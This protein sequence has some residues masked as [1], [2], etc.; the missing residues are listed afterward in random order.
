MQPDSLAGGLVVE[1]S[2]PGLLILI[3]QVEA[4]RSP[5]GPIWIPAKTVRVRA[6]R[7]DPRRFDSGS[8]EAL[9]A[10][11]PGVV[12][13]VFLDLR[14]SVMLRSVP[15]P[16]R[17]YRIVGTATDSL[18]GETPLSLRSALL[19]GNRFRLEA[20]DHADSVLAGESLLSLDASTGRVAISLRR[21]AETLPP[22]PRKTPLLRK[23]W[24]QWTLVG[25]GAAL[26][27]TAAV[28]RRDG[29]RWYNRYLESSDRR[30]LDTYFDR[31]VRYDHLSLVS[32]GAGQALFTGGLVLLVNGSGR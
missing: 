31:A 26:T 9:A 27:G 5:V 18:L 7:D 8:D 22:S 15:E 1:T 21:V 2:P 4:G 29:D 30:V 13:R 10:L 24:L 16:A 14:P 28:F 11:Q 6:L 17:V 25:I 32:L 3:D 19:E 20:R 12:T 23:R